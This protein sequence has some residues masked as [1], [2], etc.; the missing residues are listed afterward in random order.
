M[1]ASRKSKDSSNAG[2]LHENVLEAVVVA[3]S[4]C[5]RFTPITDA[6]SKVSK[7]AL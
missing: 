7:P 6:R 5:S 3:D 1:P 2:L 4:F